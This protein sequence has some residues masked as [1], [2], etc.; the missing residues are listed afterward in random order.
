MQRLDAAAKIQRLASVLLYIYCAV[1]YDASAGQTA[2]FALAMSAIQ[3]DVPEK[4][5]PLRP[6]VKI[7]TTKRRSLR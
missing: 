3:S 6:R 7:A 2:G 5:I 4:G 1:H